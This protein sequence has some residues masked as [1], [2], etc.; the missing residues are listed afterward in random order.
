MKAGMGM[1]CSGAVTASARDFKAGLATT[2]LD[3]GEGGFTCLRRPGV[4]KHSF[5]SS[6]AISMN[7]SLCRSSIYT[8]DQIGTGP[9]VGGGRA[10]I[11]RFT[12]LT[13]SCPLSKAP[14]PRALTL[15]PGHTAHGPRPP[16]TV[17]TEHP[18][19]GPRVESG[20]LHQPNPSFINEKTVG[21]RVFRLV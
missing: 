10:E 20:G 15:W 3:R 14:G 21:R 12:H 5:W 1:K 11:Q 19:I 13:F 16:P 18:V 17:S 7:K 8:I 6:R 9:L 4:L 2:T